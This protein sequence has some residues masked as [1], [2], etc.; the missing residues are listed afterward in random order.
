[1]DKETA[2]KRIAE[3]SEQLNEHNYRYYVLAQPHISDYK[4]DMLMEELQKLEKLFPELI[5]P[6]SPSQ[7]VGG[8]ITKSFQTYP[9]RYPML[10]LSNSYNSNEI[11][12]FVKRVKKSTSDQVSFVCELKYDGVAVSLQYEKG[13]LVRALTRGNGTEGDD[14]TTNVKTIRSIPLRLKGNFPESFEIRGEIYYPKASFEKLNKERAALGLPLFANPRNAAA[15]TIKMQDSAEVS[16]RKLDCWLYYLM[17]DDNSRQFDTHYESLQEAKKWGFRV[18]NN[19][20]LCQNEDEIFEFINDWDSGRHELPF[21]IDGIVIKVNSFDQQKQLGFTAK[22]PRWAIAYKYKAEEAKTKLLSI[23]FQVGRTGAVTP[24]AN[25]E[26]VLLAGTTVKRASLH[27]ADFIAQLDLH[28]D[29]VVTV[30]K[31]GEII[32]KITDVDKNLRN[33][34]STAVNFI[35]NCPECG[36]KLTRIDGESAWYCP[37]N[38]GCPPQIKGKIEHFI[39]RKAMN[40]ESLGEGKIALLFDQGL[41]KNAADLYKLTFEDLFGLEKIIETPDESNPGNIIRRKVSFKEKTAENIL[42]S[43]DESKNIPFQRVLFAL[44]IRFVGETVAKKLA[45]AFLSIDNLI[46]ANYESLIAVDEIGDKIA[47]SIQTYFEEASHIEM[48]EQLKKAGLQFTQESK[49]SKEGPLHG[50]T[51]VISGVFS[52]SRDDLKDIIES[53]GGTN[54]SSLSKKTNFLIAGENMGPSKKEKAIKLGIPIL[55]EADLYELIEKSNS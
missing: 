30:E 19:F 4:Y 45:D 6:D 16:R 42:S 49:I 43:L 54:T 51:F 8:D 27:N 17:M 33:S 41:I 3:L 13:L 47:S 26:P 35:E 55:S 20:A 23:D 40:I 22:S 53:N 11:A 44:G 25:L 34:N 48:I 1:M 9:H 2:H 36:T 46:N 31:G 50:K 21:E 37:N 12:E 15:G 5:K 18:S 10:S 24:V 39:S 7:R 29:D 52:I 28:Y 14:I 32:H 38:D